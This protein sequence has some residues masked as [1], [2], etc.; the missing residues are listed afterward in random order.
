MPSHPFVAQRPLFKAYDIRGKHALFTPPFVAALS[1]VFARYLRDSI[2]ASQIV[3]GYDMRQDSQTIAEQFALSCRQAGVEVIWLGLVTTPIMVF[4]ANQYQGHGLITTA[5]HST[6]FINGIKWVVHGQ[7]PSSEDIIALYDQLATETYELSP[8]LET[9]ELAADLTNLDPT[10]LITLSREQVTAPY[11]ASA[12][13]AI[14]HIQPLYQA[15]LTHMASNTAIPNA[16]PLKVVIDCLNG[17]TGPFAPLFFG[18]LSNLCAEAVLLNQDPN[19]QF[20]KGDPDPTQPH[21]L[22]ELQ[23]SVIEHQADIGLGFDGDGDRL[24]V[25]DNLGRPLAPDHL[26]YLLA[27][28]AVE[29]YYLGHK[30]N[31]DLNHDTNSRVEVSAANNNSNQKP[32]VIF[33]VKCAHQVP[34]L[35]EQIGATGQMSKTGSSILRHAVYAK[36]RQLADNYSP[37]DSTD[38]EEQGPLFAGELS[39]HF[40]FNDGYFLLHDD[41]MYA[42][43]RLLNWLVYNTQR[44]Q[45]VTN[46]SLQL[47]DILDG[48]PPL[49]ST[50]DE[51]LPLSGLTDLALSPG[52]SESELEPDL[53]NETAS[54]DEMSAAGK[55]TDTHEFPAKVA[56]SVNSKNPVQLVRDKLSQLCQ[57][58]QQHPETLN[59]NFAPEKVR[60]S[61]I[62][63]LR[64]DFDQG[65]GIIRLCNYPLK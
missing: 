4:W 61:C 36:S 60:L 22:R 41:A 17:A 27:Q 54:P 62:D 3:I 28:V 52:L 44:Y 9:T 32:I 58:L 65:F 21:R 48:L 20:P 5:S 1:R 23:A 2:G 13:Q 35:L 26:L 56:D 11:F 40:L 57:R 53:S 15:Q 24:M 47:S 39:G 25:V 18:Q 38:A 12:K 50:A 49:V 42:G 31:V 16:Q 30:H 51:Y 46:K 64:L 43:L 19:G 55:Y 34:Q 29:D 59:L 10:H 33:D 14:D 37:A 8:E 6:R 45:L 63:G 7:S